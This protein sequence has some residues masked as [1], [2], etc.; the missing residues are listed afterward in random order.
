MHHNFIHMIFCNLKMG[1]CITLPKFWNVSKF[2]YFKSLTGSIGNLEKMIRSFLV[3]ANSIISKMRSSFMHFQNV[4]NFINESHHYIL[5][6]AYVFYEPENV[7][8][9]QMALFFFHNT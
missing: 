2:R 9:V 4:I 1:E 7:L 3:S 8:S 5:C 6:T